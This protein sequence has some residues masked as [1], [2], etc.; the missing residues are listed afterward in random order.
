[1]K[2]A[3]EFRIGLWTIIAIVVMVVGIKYL[4]GQLHTTTSYYVISPNVERVGESSHVKLNGYKVGYVSDMQINYSTNEVLLELSIDPNLKL[5][6]GTAANIQP[7]LLGNSNVFLTLGES[8]EFLQPGDTLKGGGKAPGLTDGIADAIPV[9]MALLPKIDTLLT[10]LNVLVNDSK[11]Q[12]SL[13]QINTL[14]RKLDRTIT[15]LNRDLPGIMGHID[16]A[17]AN[18][19]TLSLELRQ[20]HVDQLIAEATSTLDSVN[21]VVARL[22]GTEGTAGKLINS[23]ELHTRLETTLASIDSLVTDIKQHPRRY[24]NIKLFGK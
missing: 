24:I 20:A 2:K 3:N 18:L 6:K 10:G 14:T 17:S 22:N 9:V 15:D 7:D 1:M 5:P 16:Q 23:D 13:L 12:E 8:P 11:L 19:D 4:K 21:V